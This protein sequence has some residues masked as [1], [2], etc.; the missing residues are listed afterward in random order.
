MTKEESEHFLK[1]LPADWTCPGSAGQWIEPRGR[2]QEEA[3]KAASESIAEQIRQDTA[4]G[5]LPD[6]ERA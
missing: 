6:P 2:M 4:G 1:A 3:D 5:F